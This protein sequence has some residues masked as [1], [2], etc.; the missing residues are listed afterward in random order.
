MVS[1]LFGIP[2]MGAMIYFHWILHTPM[3]PEMQTPVL[4][5]A[6]S[7]DNLVLFALCTP[8]QVSINTSQYLLPNISLALLKFM[9]HSQSCTFHFVSTEISFSHNG[10]RSNAHLK[11]LVMLGSKF[12][13]FATVFDF[14]RYLVENTFTCKAGER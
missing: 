3:H 14:F 2:V 4:T 12:L 9:F 13:L 1:L 10:V 5:P 8:V 7:L 11:I 6:L